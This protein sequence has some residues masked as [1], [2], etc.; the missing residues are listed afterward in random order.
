MTVTEYVT[1]WCTGALALTVLAAL[2]ARGRW[3]R[4]GSFALYLGS[5]GCF[6]VAVALWG[7]ALFHWSTWVVA[8]LIQGSLALACA[9]EICGRVFE[10]LPRGLQTA[11]LALLG[12]LGGGAMLTWSHEASA[13]TALSEF[14]VHMV[15][16]FELATAAVFVSLLCVILFFELP[17][18]DLHAAI[19]RGLATQAGVS[20]VGLQIVREF[21]W[22]TREGVSVALSVGYA[23]LLVYW[24]AASWRHEPDVPA[25]IVAKLWP[26]RC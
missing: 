22:T 25:A 20:A 6:N 21:G 5:V 9:V 16:R 7:D 24:L 12:C 17:V 11:R 15:P 23:T 4:C 18:D 3:R 10:T 1:L 2:L 14:A 19:A 13:A 8:E 26:W